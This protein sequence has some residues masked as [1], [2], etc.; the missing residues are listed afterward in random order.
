MRWLPHRANLASCRRFLSRL[1]GAARSRFVPCHAAAV[2]TTEPLCL[3]LVAPGNPPTS[4]IAD[5][6]QTTLSQLPRRERLLSAQSHV[7][8]RG[9]SGRLSIGF[10]S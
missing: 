2:P 4:K 1:V 10:R 7:R 6:R 9:I 5:P 8:H 3:S